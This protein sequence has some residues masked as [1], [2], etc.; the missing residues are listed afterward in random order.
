[1]EAV[2]LPL[3]TPAN[4]AR[5]C[6]TAVYRE[7]QDT[8]ALCQRLGQIGVITGPTGVGKTTA[9]RDFAKTDGALYLRMTHAAANAQPFLH[10]VC[11]VLCGYTPA[12][13]GKYELYS[14]IIRQTTRKGTLL[15][16][17]EGCRL[18]QELV[19][20]LHDI[21]DEARTYDDHRIGIALVGTPEM[22]DLWAERRARKGRDP[23]AP[24][25]ARI[26]QSLDVKGLKDADINALCVHFG[27]RGK[28]ERDV[29]ASVARTWEG[30]HNVDQ[31]M[32]NARLLAGTGNAI[33]SDHLIEA[34]K[35]MGGR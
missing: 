25:R 17:D 1:M 26:G 14:L 20:I 22:T 30:L 13:S 31:L 19:L 5:H 7:I 29:V 16:I 18:T 33:G 4:K 28:R 10:R 27:V 6:E 9:C 2:I 12:N 11:E 32:T 24:F 15:I 35:V 34:A 21:W 23:F 8:L 3:S